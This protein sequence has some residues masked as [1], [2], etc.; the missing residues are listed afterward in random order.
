MRCMPTIA[1]DCD[2]IPLIGMPPAASAPS[3]PR[4]LDSTS[5]ARSGLDHHRT[6]LDSRAEEAARTRMMSRSSLQQGTL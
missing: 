2:G 6:Q 1:R 5:R 4:Q 3:S